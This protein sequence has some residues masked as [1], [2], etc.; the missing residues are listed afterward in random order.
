MP[1]IEPTP[2]AT[3][4]P[5][6]DLRTDIRVAR[7]Q[8]RFI[9]VVREMS[10]PI[11]VAWT[12]NVNER[13]AR[14]EV[15]ESGGKYWLPP[16]DPADVRRRAMQQAR[17]ELDFLFSD[18]ERGKLDDFMRN[19]IGDAEPEPAAEPFSGT[20]ADEFKRARQEVQKWPTRKQRED[21]LAA[22]GYSADEIRRILGNER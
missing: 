13:I 7:L 17:Q 6:R 22:S 18:D 21:N 12:E 14:G 15:V 1:G 8:T 3:T 5:K 9:D 4:K 10:E 11:E 20:E 2:R 16:P 19:L